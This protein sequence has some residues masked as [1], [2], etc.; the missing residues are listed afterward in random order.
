[1]FSDRF[2]AITR[3]TISLGW[4]VSVQQ[5]LNTLMRT[6][7]IL[8]TGFFSPA[9]VAAIGLA[10]L[11]ARIPLRIG[12]G[13]GSGAIALS[14]QDTGRGAVDTRDRAI[15]QALLIGALTGVPLV[16]VGLLFSHALI[17]ILGAESEVVR[18]GGL[19]LA[20]IFAASPFRIVAMVGARSLQGTGDT[21]TPMFAN[22]SAT[23]L[24]IVLTIGLGLGIWIA[25]T[26]G[27]IGV[28]IATAVSRVVEASLILIAIG[29]PKTAP[30]F[31]RPTTL[32]IT[33]QLI[34]VSLPDIAGG[35]SSEIANFPVNAIILLFGTEA[36]AAYHIASRVYQQFTA[37]L[38]R[39]FR[40]VS[41][42][43]VGQELGAGQHDQARYAARSISAISLAILSAAGLIL[44]IGAEL[45]ALLFT[46]DA[47]TV[48]FATDFNRAY[49]IAMV[50]IALYFPLAGAL[51]GAG[52]TR[53]PFYAAIVGS[54]VFLLG[55]SYV[56]GILLDLGLLGVY[57]SI[58]LSYVARATIVVVGIRWGSWVELSE[59][60]IAERAEDES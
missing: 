41:S 43:I 34:G 39:A 9:A 4:P 28:G 5:S 33:R 17:E 31:A 23:G 56:L 14:S 35:L 44:F 18:L 46:R 59:R 40:T 49:A 10:D 45:F 29:S 12:M 13:L 52:D 42:I 15:S 19:Y 50:F 38:F 11:Y 3:Q 51:R 25:P 37:P 48:A 24:N 20:I 7:D 8:V 2:R 6:V 22:G 16:I 26:L 60:L 32:T 27:I 47:V 30:S 57:I 58:V 21:R 1:M 36:N 55:G 54:Y 53:T